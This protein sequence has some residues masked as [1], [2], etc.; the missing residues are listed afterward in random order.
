MAE[1]QNSSQAD[2]DRDAIA[3]AMTGM[4]PRDEKG[5]LAPVEIF[6]T[7][8]TSQSNAT[9]TTTEAAATP[10]ETVT[11]EVV[12][13]EQQTTQTTEQAAETSTEQIETTITQEPLELPE[14]DE[15]DVVGLLQESGLEVDSLQEIQEA[16]DL[17]VKYKEAQSEFS[18]LT[19]D[20][21]RRIAITRKF[22]DP[23]LYDK[24]SLINADLIPEKEILKQVFFLQN[25]GKSQLFLNEQFERTFK[26]DY[27]TF[28]EDDEQE[29]KFLKL[30]LEEDAK[31][32]RDLMK[33]FQ[34]ELKGTTLGTTAADTTKPEDTEEYQKN[35]T[36]SVDRVLENADKIIYEVDG[37]QISVVMDPTSR[38]AVQQAMYDPIA[39]IT[40]LISDENGN[41]DHEAEFEFVMRNI[42]FEKILGEAKNTGRATFQEAQLKAAKNMGTTT[43]LK[44]EPPKVTAQDQFA[45]WANSRR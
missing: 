13:P 45:N 41:V 44:V 19:E 11:S 14:L 9:T 17:R 25:S 39:W 28:E 38:E 16:L 20:E 1:E 26:R 7:P 12:I 33:Q 34:D 42:F 8:Q 22:G 3:Q 37:A 21:R 4:G 31:E 27:E 10:Q 6:K 32:A 2:I 35:W 36:A 40:A 23:M 15:Y 29:Q 24:V 18:G 43:S 5:N 30:K